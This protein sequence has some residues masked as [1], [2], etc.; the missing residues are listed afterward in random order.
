MQITLPL[1]QILEYENNLD[2]ASHPINSGNVV[3]PTLKSQSHAYYFEANVGQNRNK[4][5]I[6]VGYAWLRQEQDSALA[7][8]TESDQRAPTNILQHRIFGTWR[9]APNV[10]AGYTLWVGRTLNRNLINS[11]VAKGFNPQ[12]PGGGPDFK[13]PEPWLKRMQFDL[14]YTF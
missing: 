1:N 2:A 12:L 4:G 6:Q 8:F 11:Q 3:D 10:T 13:A 5:D 14:I 9:L 7:S